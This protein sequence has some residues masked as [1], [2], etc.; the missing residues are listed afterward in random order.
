ML[1]RLALAAVLMSLPTLALAQGAPSSAVCDGAEVRHAERMRGVGY[2]LVAGT[3]AADLVAM[4][5]IPRNPGGF[6]T[7]RS[8][9]GFVAATAPVALAGYFIAARARPGEGFWERVIPRLKV[10]ETRSADVRLCL[11]RPDIATSSGGEQ[12]W[13]YVTAR[14]ST[15]GGTLRTV[16]LTFRDSVL[17]DV[18]RTEVSRYAIGWKRHA[19]DDDDSS[20][21]HR[22][23]TPPTPVIADPFPTP[24]DTT[25][26]AAAM[27]RAQADADAASKNAANAAAYAACMGGY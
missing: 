24:T 12:R 4:L 27:A 15:L 20:L 3:T 1:R 14:P 5:T 8:H 10:G 9:F 13:T 23:C 19:A 7:A 21:P 6:S 11:R 25:A 18:Q 22:F 2:A 16:R 26:A 17:T